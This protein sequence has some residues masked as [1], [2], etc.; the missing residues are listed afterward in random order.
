MDAAQMWAI[1]GLINRHGED[2][3]VQTIRTC[4]LR[5]DGLAIGIIDIADCAANPQWISRLALEHDL[6]SG[7]ATLCPT[8]PFAFLRD[9]KY[10]DP[11]HPEVERYAGYTKK[12][13]RNYRI[14]EPLVSNPDLFHPRTRGRLIETRARHCKCTEKHVRTLLRRYFQRGQMKNAL[15]PD[16]PRSGQG[17]GIRGPRVNFLGKTL[18]KLTSCFTDKDNQVRTVTG[19]YALFVQYLEKYFDKEG[20]SL[21]DTLDELH[22]KVFNCGFTI[23]DGEKIPILKPKNQRPTLDHLKHFYRRYWNKDHSRRQR[24]GDVGYGTTSRP[25]NKGTQDMAQGPGQLIQGD[26]TPPDIVVVGS[27]RRTESNGR[28]TLYF[29]IDHFS[30]LVCGFSISLRNE[31]YVSVMMALDH[32]S[33]DKVAYCKGLGI[34]IA[35]SD[36]PVA[37]VPRRILVDN[38]VLRQWKGSHLVNALNIRVVNTPAYRG[39][40]KAL[41][42]RLHLSIKKRIRRLPGTTIQAKAGKKQRPGRKAVNTIEDLTKHVIA[43]VLCHNNTTITKYRRTKD[44]IRDQVPPIPSHLW[45]WG[46]KKALGKPR[47]LP[48]E[49]LRLNLLPLVQGTVTDEG[50]VVEGSLYT[51]PDHLC[52]KARQERRFKVSVNRDPRLPSEVFIRDPAND[53]NAISC[54]LQDE[55]LKGLDSAEI[56]LL[57]ADEKALRHQWKDHDAQ[58]RA[59][60]NARH[61][62]ISRTAK[63]EQKKA[64]KEQGLAHNNDGNVAEARAEGIRL[65]NEVN[66]WR[67]LGDKTAATT[68]Q[69]N[70]EKMREGASP[71]SNKYADALRM[72]LEE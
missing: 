17:R 16:F 41:V 43:E 49:T 15:L 2:G 14:I 62:A 64:L 53:L 52:A 66:A 3:T 57:Q 20:L 48:Q 67:G 21:S 37:N 12:R 72:A 26:A 24:K 34:T 31:C 36:W 70:T 4:L 10:D 22:A 65:E 11:R 54:V 27:I 40:L 63:K 45:A 42:E 23:Q 56:A 30:H 28:A 38:G 18:Q 50:L 19:L 9:P 32:M 25:R 69:I 35:R 59:T 51:C 8:D 58:Q 68:D 47:W 61:D 7:E 29:L 71:P 46:C 55:A 60:R 1:D 39:D 33:T 5:E 6:A 13:D 44:M